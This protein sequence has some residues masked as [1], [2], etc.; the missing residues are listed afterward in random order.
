MICRF[1]T[2]PSRTIRHGNSQFQR[3]YGS[4][5][6]KNRSCHQLCLK[7]REIFSKPAVE[8]SFR[9][10]VM[11]FEHFLE[12]ISRRRWVFFRN[13]RNPTPEIIVLASK[14]KKIIVHIWIFVSNIGK[15][16]VVTSLVPG[17]IL[18]LITLHYHLITKM[19][20]LSYR[21]CQSHCI[22]FLSVKYR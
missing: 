21:L 15:E 19:N 22:R 11:N 5:I 1:V 14:K 18:I 20:F 8:S 12:G 3:F 4:S 16:W 7:S 6:A 2:S 9:I 17:R 10:F 13:S